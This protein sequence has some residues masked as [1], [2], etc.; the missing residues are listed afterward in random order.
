[1]AVVRSRKPGR[2]RIR[3]GLVAALSAAVATTAACG[4]D[5]G[6]NGSSAQAAP[7]VSLGPVVR[8]LRHSVR[9]GRVSTAQ[10]ALDQIA[11]RATAGAAA[12]M[13]GVSSLTPKG[14]NVATIVLEHTTKAAQATEAHYRAVYRALGGNA[15]GLLT[16]TANAVVA[17]GARPEP[18]QRAA[19][20]H[21]LQPTR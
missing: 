6:A 14:T 10:A 11:R 13:F 15:N 19:I 18:A 8:C 2:L 21:C 12:V 9:H 3:A 5:D 20:T 7:A 17:F 4:G 16:R 1:M